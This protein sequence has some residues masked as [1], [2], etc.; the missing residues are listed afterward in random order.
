[1]PSRRDAENRLPLKP[2]DFHI[3]FS[4]LDGPL[5]GYGIAKTILDRTEGGIRLEAGNLQRTLR[6]LVR[7]ALVAPSIDRPD[8]EDDDA[9]R[10]YWQITREGRAAVAAE[11]LRLRRLVREAEARRLIP[12][13]PR[14]R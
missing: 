11:A 13:T 5:H 10:N 9:R 8:P 6:K 3:L 12:L 2:N 1:V 7:Q 4:L 14:G